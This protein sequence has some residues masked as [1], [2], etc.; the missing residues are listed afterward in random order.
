MS[1]I[2]LLMSM[3]QMV[4]SIPS[5]GPILAK[6]VALA[7]L[8]SAAASAVVGVWHAL[9]GVIVALSKVPGL[10]SLQALSEKL[11]MYDDQAQGVLNQYILPSLDRLSVLPLPQKPSA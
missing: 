4:S 1:V 7:G 9:V 8:L 10:Q 6:A 2:N 11:R 5:V 3:I